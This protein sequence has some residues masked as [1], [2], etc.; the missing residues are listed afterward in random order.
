MKPLFSF[1]VFF[2]SLSDIFNYLDLLRKYVYIMNEEDCKILDDSLE[3]VY[4]TFSLQKRLNEHLSL[5]D[6]QPSKS[7]KPL[8]RV[9]KSLPPRSRFELECDKLEKMRETS[10]A[11]K[12]YVGKVLESE[13]C[14]HKIQPSEVSFRWQIGLQIGKG[15]FGIVYSCVN[16]DTGGIMALKIIYLHKIM[17]KKQSEKVDAI[18]SEINNVLRIEHPN[19]VKMFGAE[20]NRVSFFFI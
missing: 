20:L 11:D 8:H 19:L 10:L 18:A 6:N 13:R 15:R 1:L 9:N 17:K 12:G 14:D 7:L 16:L 3:P 5:T 2:S 4:L